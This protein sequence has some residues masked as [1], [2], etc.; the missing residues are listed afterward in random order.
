M[1]DD[2]TEST[3]VWIINRAMVSLVEQSTHMATTALID[4]QRAG[5]EGSRG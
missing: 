4:A 2:F 5:A 1:R 3:I